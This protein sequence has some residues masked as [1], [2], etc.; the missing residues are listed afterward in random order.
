[1]W[2]RRVDQESDISLSPDMSSRLATSSCKSAWSWSSENID[3]NRGQV[4]ECFALS[5]SPFNLSYTDDDGEEFSLRNE[6]DFTEAISYFTSGD[7]DQA[8]STY[9]GD[10]QAHQATPSYSLQKINLRLEVVVEYDGPS[11]SD[12]S[13]IL[14][15]TTSVDDGESRGESSRSS[16]RYADD[17]ASYTSQNR[18]SRVYVDDEVTEYAGSQNDRHSRDLDAHLGELQ[19]DGAKSEHPI[20]SPMSETTNIPGHHLTL[21][22]QSSGRSSTRRGRLRVSPHDS[23][24]RDSR[25]PLPLTGTDSG[26]A[27]SLLT[28]SELGTRWLREQSNLATARRV[29]ARPGRSRRSRRDDSD[30]SDDGEEASVE[31]I[32]LVQDARGSESLTSQF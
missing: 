11:L 17:I 26:S 24:G 28:H 16:R 6:I 5:A 21:S 14:S 30:E 13:S 18:Q 15:F 1:M 8:L 23:P 9:S 19:L 22:R 7:D 29:G 31:D 27:P 2:I 25:Q 3:H 32:A 4:E 12:T 20:Q 10:G